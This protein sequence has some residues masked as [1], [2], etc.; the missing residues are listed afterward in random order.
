A[1]LQRLTVCRMNVA[2]VSKPFC[3]Q[4]H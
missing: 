4:Q 3:F 2:G 1:L